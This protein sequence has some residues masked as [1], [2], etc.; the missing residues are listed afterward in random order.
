MESLDLGSRVEHGVPRRGPWEALGDSS[1]LPGDVW[2]VCAV[3]FRSCL[4]PALAGCPKEGRGQ[5]LLVLAALGTAGGVGRGFMGFINLR[6]LALAILA[7]CGPSCSSVLP[8]PC[9]RV[10]PGEPQQHHCQ[11]HWEK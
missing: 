11:G 7:G 6:D 8:L 1:P 10:S 2:L 3:S 9:A 4:S 5:L